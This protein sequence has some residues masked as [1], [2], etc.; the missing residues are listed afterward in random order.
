MAPLHQKDGGLMAAFS[1]KRIIL[2][3]VLMA[4][5]IHA[6][7]HAVVQTHASRRHPWRHQV[8]LP[9]NNE[10]AAS[11]LPLYS[12]Y[13]DDIEQQQQQVSSSIN[14]A[15]DPDSDEAKAVTSRLGLT[16][17]QHKQLSQLASLVVD[18]N[19]R[20]NLVSRR[21]CNVEVVFGRHIL[22]SIALASTNEEW[23][24]KKVIDVGTGGGFPGLPLA[25]AYPDTQFMLVDSVGKKLKAVEEMSNELDL[26]NV[27]VH[28]GRAE[29]M[30]DDILEGSRH[31]GA[32]DVCVGR[33][34]AALPKFCFW[35]NELIKPES[36]RLVYIIGGDIEDSLLSQADSHV[37]IDNVLEQDGASD[38]RILIFDQEAVA[39]IAAASGEV[40]RKRG[41]PKAKVERTGKKAKGQWTKR[42]IK[43]KKRGY[44]DFKRYS[45][46]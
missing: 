44:D 32:Y 13:D 28:H 45:T 9:A 17:Q 18:W 24:D 33:S 6:A 23:A 30:V 1:P 36:G 29:E 12:S 11:H 40:K 41:K 22:P 46:D 16:E 2:L 38:K 20:I 39:S 43:P 31:E 10:L 35:I 26:I 7:F 15:M 19:E 27:R 42:D 3:I 14:F 8:I 4:T 25:I 37:A 34:V 5:E 21:D